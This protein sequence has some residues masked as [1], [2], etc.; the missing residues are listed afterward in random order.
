ME[1]LLF[2]FLSISSIAVMIP[3]TDKYGDD[4]AH[5]E[6]KV[7]T[8]GPYVQYAD[9]QVLI[10]YIFDKKG[11]KK[12]KTEN[13]R[14]AKKESIKLNVGTDIQDKTF[15]VTL[16]GNLQNEKSEFPLVKKILLLS[17]IEGNFT[18]FRKLLQAG[19][20]IDENF[21][22]TFGEGH[23]VLAGDFFD[24]GQQVTEVL[25]FIYYL[26]EKAKAAGGYVHFILGNHEIMNLV[27]DLRYTQQKYLENAKLFTSGYMELYNKN[28]ELGRWLLTKN[29]VEKIGDL[30]V[31][32]GG[33]SASMNLMNIPVDTINSLARPFYG[34]DAFDENDKKLSIIFGDLGPLWYRGYY[35]IRNTGIPLQIDSTLNQ[36]GVNH[37]IT[38]HTIVADTISMWYNGKLLDLDVPHAEGK[39]EALLIED[40]K[41]YRIN[42]EGKKMLLM[43]ANN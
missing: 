32:H 41:F 2:A 20:V 12:V 9:D 26:E 33:I 23:L 11:K 19:S 13:V 36:F 40:G 28:S 3:A 39:S 14:L 1:K 43:D 8:D 35:D 18:A 34:D 22:W 27:G 38:G 5:G 42:G 37:V 29:I 10:T 17:D 4:P 16:K 15:A 7:Q 21:N 24:R 30:L 31:L 6:P 25:W